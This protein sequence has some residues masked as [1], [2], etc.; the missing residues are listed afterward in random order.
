M[1]IKLSLEQW[2]NGPAPDAKVTSGS[3][4]D[5]WQNGNLGAQQAH[6]KE[7]EFVAYRDV[8]TGL[9]EGGV[10]LTTMQW[11]TTKGGK[12]A[13]DYLGTFDTSFPAGR[14]ETI[15]NPITGLAFAGGPATPTTL[16]IPIDPNAIA[17]TA[18]NFTF[19]GNITDLRYIDPGADNIV[20]TADD[21][22]FSPGADGVWGGADD[23]LYAKVGNVAGWGADGRWGTGDDQVAETGAGV[24]TELGSVYRM[25]GSYTGD[26]STS[27]TV[28]FKYVGDGAGGA[29]TGNVVAAWSGH[30]ATR[31]DWG[32]GN[33]A[34]GI[35]GSPYHM[36][37]EGFADNNPAT[38]E[39]VGQQDRSLSSEA[40][41]FP[42]SI[43][44]VKQTTGNTVGSFNFEFTRPADSVDVIDGKLDLSGDGLVDGKDD[45]RFTE[46][47]GEVFTVVDGLITAST[48]GDGVLDSGTNHFQLVAGAVDVNGGGIGMTDDF[49]NLLGG[50]I[51]TFTLANGGQI[52]FGNLDVGVTY[53]VKE[54]TQSGWQLTSL[55]AVVSGG[56]VPTTSVQT[57]VTS[58]SLAEGVNWTVTYTNLA[59]TPSL[60]ITKV[61]TEDSVDAAGDIIHYT[62]TV[63]NTGN[64]TLTGVDVDDA[65]VA[66]LA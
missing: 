17:Q 66:N 50:G 25:T 9:T 39:G 63:E 5:T 35:S 20:N 40:V 52:T 30:I 56:A 54:L 44:V 31:A 64:V 4:K 45:G 55:N 37:L 19:Y 62:V 29:T 16:G 22:A 58:G 34:V 18:G 11:D 12:H 13:I 32:E 42:G 14:D 36:R 6:Y 60:T 65:L 7:G 51:T 33:S 27:L 8:Y 59:L 2:A 49:S 3:A 24:A 10:Y 23:I 41:V 15:P 48:G 43:T 47:G 28:M 61:A 21:R 57:G 1:P 53:A 38:S 26:S 46:A